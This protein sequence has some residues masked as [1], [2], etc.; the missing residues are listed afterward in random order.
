MLRP[1]RPNVE[2]QQR[3]EVRVGQPHPHRVQCVFRAILAAFSLTGCASVSVETQHA[4][5]D[6]PFF[7][8]EQET[9]IHGRKNWLDYLVEADPGTFRVETAADYQEHPPAVIAVLPFGDLGDANFT[10]D[11][12]P[13]TFRNK[14]EQEHWAW[15]DAQ[16]LRL[17]V[18]GHLAQREFTIVNSISVDAILKQLGINSM[19][20]LKRLRPLQLGRLLGADALVY[21][22][23]DNYEGY[24]FGIISAYLVAV[25][26][27][28][29]SAHDGE[30]LINAKGSR[31]SVGLEPAVSPQGVAISSIKTLLS[32][33]T[34]LEFRDV[35]LARA[36][37]EVGRELVLR[38]P[39]SETLK[40]HLAKRASTELA[41]IVSR[42][43]ANNATPDSRQPAMSLATTQR[44]PDNS[45]PRIRQ[46]LGA[47]QYAQAHQ[48][49]V[50]ATGHSSELSDAERREV[51]DD[52][53]LTEYLIGPPSYPLLEEERVCARALGEPGSVSGPNLAQIRE[54]SR[55]SAEEQVRNSLKA[56]QLAEAE[57]AALTYRA[58]PG[59]DAN[60]LAEWAKNF[61]S[62]AHDQARSAERTQEVEP[63]VSLLAAAYP[64][65]KSMSDEDFESWIVATATASDTPFVSK[66]D[67]QN[68]TTLDLLVSERNLPAVAANLYKFVRINDALAARCRCDSRTNID[69]AETG[70]PAYLLRLDPAARGSTV[71]IAISEPEAPASREISQSFL[72][73]K[74]AVQRSGQRKAFAE[75]KS[76][77]PAVD[78]ASEAPANT[79]PSRRLDLQ[80]KRFRLSHGRLRVRY[81]HR[82]ECRA[83]Q[84]VGLSSADVK[85]PMGPRLTQAHAHAAPSV[86]SYA[87]LSGDRAADRCGKSRRSAVVSARTGSAIADR[88]RA[89][90]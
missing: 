65:M 81:I 60:L 62:V 69:V 24:Y 71:L 86:G 47:G 89:R 57:A 64:R 79:E 14:E 52:L 78:S 49:L 88:D 85:G 5:E 32:V 36:E 21:G 23:V 74:E 38:I 12:I 56:H 55:Q 66:L 35:T 10:I 26:M 84:C 22:E 9:E 58:S 51:K 8:Q 83:W 61:W 6:R 76:R 33:K 54:L 25:R 1:E 80:G 29:I 40:T 77:L 16:R 19:R 68:D 28:M 45:L 90:N 70:F 73:L 17:S 43:P 41:T 48:D 30:T 75:S 3:P 34:L 72:S 2:S 15:T 87:R 20:K 11:K 50:L 37:E 27:W 46:E 42:P 63:M 18:M 39:V 67:M 53:C 31:Y 44:K 7:Q 13:I 4:R 82:S 59:A